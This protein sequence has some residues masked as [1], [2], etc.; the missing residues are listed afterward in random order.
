M[1]WQNGKSDKF[2]LMKLKIKLFNINGIVIYMPTSQRLEE[3]LYSFYKR[4]DSANH[5]KLSLLWT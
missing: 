3:E 4:L 5:K 2:L 1:L